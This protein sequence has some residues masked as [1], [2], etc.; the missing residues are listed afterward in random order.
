MRAPRSSRFAQSDRM[1]DGQAIR[2]RG[3]R[4]RRYTEISAI[5][6]DTVAK[7][8]RTGVYNTVGLNGAYGNQRP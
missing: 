6:G 7:D 4:A 3:T 2:R 8:L 5:Y 1:T